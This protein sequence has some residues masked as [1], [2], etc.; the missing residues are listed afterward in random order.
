MRLDVLRPRVPHVQNPRNATLQL[1]IPVVLLSQV[2]LVRT[3]GQA[4]HLQVNEG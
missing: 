3:L 4:T 1:P 2:R